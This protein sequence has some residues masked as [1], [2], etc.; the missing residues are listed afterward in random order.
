M[1]RQYCY[2]LKQGLQSNITKYVSLACAQ[3][4]SKATSQPFTFVAKLFCLMLVDIHHMY[5]VSQK[6]PP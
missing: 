5:S 1:Q 6:N 3:Q 4:V 2:I